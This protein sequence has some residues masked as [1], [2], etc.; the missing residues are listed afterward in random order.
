[1]VLNIFTNAKD[2]FVSQKRTDGKIECFFSQ[3]GEIGT[4][5]IRDNGGGIPQDL[6]PDKI[7]E[8]HVSTKGDKGSG[9]GLSICR[10]IIEQHMGGRIWAH[11][12]DDGAEFVIELPIVP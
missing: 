2:V 12:V 4:I 7:F 1:M 6:L 10:S 5:R 8:E 11:N 9:I 3:K